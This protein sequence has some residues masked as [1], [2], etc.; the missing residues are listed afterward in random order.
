ME[1]DINV[2]FKKE[3]LMKYTNNYNL[4]QAFVDALT[5][6]DYDYE[7]GVISVSRLISP[8]HQRRLYD[9][10]RND[11]VEDAINKV[12]TLL[13]TAT[14]AYAEK[15]NKDKYLIEKRFYDI[16]EDQKISAKIDLYDYD[17]NS[18]QDFKTTSKY[19]FK[20][21]KLPIEYIQQ[22]NV[23]AYLMKKSGYEVKKLYINAIFKDWRQSD[24]YDAGMPSTPAMSYE[25]PLWSEDKQYA[26]ILERIK[27]HLRDDITVCT[28]EERWAVKPKFAVMKQNRKTAIRLLDSESEAIIYMAN[29]NYAQPVYY[30]EKREGEDKR[31]TGYCSVNSFCSYYQKKYI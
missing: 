31:C 6:D 5:Y 24:L 21:G 11:I 25:I 2:I 8:P 17:N 12:H 4:T 14:H 27:Y 16:I 7:E 30:I 15:A 18:I 22:L 1:N 13:G 9:K 10:H 26:F 23:Q 29:H 3:K 28:P 19:K 20:D